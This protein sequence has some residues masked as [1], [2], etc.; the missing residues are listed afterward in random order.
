MVL[1]YDLE[2]KLESMEWCYKT[3]FGGHK[4]YDSFQERN[5]TVVIEPYSTLLKHVWKVSFSYK[6][7]DIAPVYIPTV[8]KVANRDYGTGTPTVQPELW[9]E[10]LLITKFK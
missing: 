7:H 4:V 1:Y 8:S 6:L 9:H 2:S 5:N 3:F 10:L